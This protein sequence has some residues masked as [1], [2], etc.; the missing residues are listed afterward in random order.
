MKT[1]ILLLACAIS[2]CTLQSQNIVGTYTNTWLSNT[3]QG[4]AYT[5]TLQKDSTFIFHYKRM[6]KEST[7]TKESIV[8][9]IWNL[10][11]HLLVLHTND[12]DSQNPITTGLDANKARFISVS[13]RNPDFNLVKPSLEFFPSDILLIKEFISSNSIESSIFP[14]VMSKSNSIPF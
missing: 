3:G 4:I 7:D 14:K 11:G 10:N 8:E 13:P 5:L 6:Y 12:T 1:L 2:T 9:G